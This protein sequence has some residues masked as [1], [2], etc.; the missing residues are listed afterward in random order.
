MPSLIVVDDPGDWPHVISDVEV[1]AASSYLTNA[2]YTARR[3]L[4]IYNL[5]RSYRYQSTGYYV[6]L[7]AAAR[8]HRPLPGVQTIQDLKSAEIVRTISEELDN[9]V[10]KSLSHLQSKDFTLSIY[11]GKNLAKR[12]ELLCRK[13]FGLFQAPLMRAQFIWSSRQSKWQLQNIGPV[14]VSDVPEDHRDFLLDAASAYF[15]GRQI[16]PKKR[17]HSRYDMAILVDPN[18]AEPPSNEKALQRFE[19]AAEQAGFSTERIGRDDYGRLAEFDALF[20]RE[21]TAVN[22]HTYRFARRAAAEGLVVIDDPK[23]I[24]KCTNK[25]FLAEILDA[26]KVPTPRTLIVHRDNRK[27]LAGQLGFPM[28]LKQPDSSFSQGV[29]KVE[30][31]SDLKET[32][33]RLM[34]RSDLIIA[35]EFLP[36]SFDWR[37]GIFDR[38]PLYACRYFMAKKHWQIYKRD[39]GGAK[40]DEGRYETVPVEHLPNTVLRTALKAAN[41]IGDG[42][43]GVDLKQAGDQTYIIEIND[44]PNI[45]AGVEDKILKNHL[46]DIIMRTLLRRVEQRKGPL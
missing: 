18:E 2:E 7:L 29:V 4:K 15:A 21:T 40:M 20:I 38:Q 27:T 8:G 24:L 10:Q 1:A 35:Q 9:L 3:G 31:E 37:V 39:L 19:K 16:S 23:S 25:V 6:S 22:H 33:E 36:T 44:N 17:K 28:V 45:D 32:L 30:K 14:A 13:L 34:N 11:F 46:Y 41:L 42:L 43:Y 5:C 26:H 12:Y